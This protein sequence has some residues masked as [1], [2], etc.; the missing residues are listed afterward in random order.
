MASLGER[1][2][3][4]DK[5]SGPLHISTNHELYEMLRDRYSISL[6]GESI[7]FD[8]SFSLWVSKFVIAQSVNWTQAMPQNLPSPHSGLQHF[9]LVFRNYCMFKDDFRLLF[10]HL[11]KFR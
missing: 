9:I 6:A 2:K 5:K 4:E 10:M 1:G 11:W 3:V 7:S 8:L